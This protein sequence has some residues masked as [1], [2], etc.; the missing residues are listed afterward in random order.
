M[1]VNKPPEAVFLQRQGSASSPTRATSPPV[2]TRTREW[3]QLRVFLCDA[4]TTDNYTFSAD[5]SGLVN[6]NTDAE[7][8]LGDDASGAVEL[9]AGLHLGQV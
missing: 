4:P 8:V 1:K 2:P 3:A 7:Q 9:S 6:M 5:C